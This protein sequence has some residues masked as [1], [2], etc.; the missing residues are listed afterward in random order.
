MEINHFSSGVARQGR[1]IAIRIFP[2]L[3]VLETIEEVC[4]DYGIQYAQITTCI[5]SL[6]RISMNFVS[7]PIPKKDATSGSGYTSQMEMDGAFS[8]LSGQGLVSPAIEQGKL[9]THLHFV[10]SGQHDAVYGGHVE[11]GTRTLTTLDLFLTELHGM[12]IVRK[13]DPVT[14][15]VVTSFSQDDE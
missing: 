6:R 2:D 1:T 7:T 3:D 8:V 10:I 13:K 5:G 15:A 9:N 11:H 12:R 14:G 4:K